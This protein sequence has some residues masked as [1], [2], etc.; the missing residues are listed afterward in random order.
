VH[1][2]NWKILQRGGK[3]TYKQ[4][5]EN[6]QA[7]VLNARWQRGHT[8]GRKCRL[9]H[10]S[11]F[12]GTAQHS[13]HEQEPTQAKND[14]LVVVSIEGGNEVAGRQV[15]SSPRKNDRSSSTVSNNSPRLGRQARQ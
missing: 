10:N 7:D 4:S 13:L 6:R 8:V 2:L 14:R 5:R 15:D 9:A 1:L 12:A 11:S 3:K